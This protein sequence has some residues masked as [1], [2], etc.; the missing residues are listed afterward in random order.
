MRELFL[1][2]GFSDF[3]SK[4]IETRALEAILKKWIPPEKQR[5]EKQRTEK[6]QASGRMAG[7]F[8]R[9]LPE[10]TAR[11]ADGNGAS[12]AE[13]GELPQKLEALRRALI[14]M[15]VRTVN[16]LL[17]DCLGMELPPGQRALAE[18]LDMLVMAFEFEKA[19]ARIQELSAATTQKPE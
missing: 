1:Q 17:A 7:A 4:P 2:N 13:N 10:R 8:D 19:V 18:E 16:D 15:D 14:S 12:F 9:V 11:E 6:Q 5:T 3:L